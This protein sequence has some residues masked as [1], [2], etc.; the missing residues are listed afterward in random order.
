M[1]QNRDIYFIAGTNSLFI[2]SRNE[3]YIMFN[4]PDGTW[5]CKQWPD[6]DGVIENR[7]PSEAARI[8]LNRAFP[9]LRR[10]GWRSPHVKLFDWRW[11]M[12][13]TGARTGRGIYID[14]KGAYW[15]IYRHL[16]LDT[17]FPCGY[18][19]LS[20]AW[21]AERLGDWKAARNSLI[22]IISA[23]ETLGVKG[24]KSVRLSMQN[25]FLAP[26]LWATVQGLLNEIAFQAEK[27]GAIY[28]ATDGYIFP[29]EKGARRFEELL[30]DYNLDYR[31]ARGTM[32]I[33][34]WGG[35]KVGKKATA[36]YDSHEPREVKSFRSINLPDQKHPLH[37]LAWWAHSIPV[38]KLQNWR[39]D[40]N[41]YRKL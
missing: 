26:A 16:W 31:I 21:V 1:L 25:P 5:V 15:Q 11:P 4:R 37:F 3:K 34:T 7:T 35:Y 18:G 33:R 8:E 10:V 24:F 40:D 19:S 17:A 38:Y 32:D 6:L 36:S 13:F 12:M 29:E 23:R 14:L 28:I 22:G 27:N 39:C 41:G 2:P 30:L 20:L 9:G